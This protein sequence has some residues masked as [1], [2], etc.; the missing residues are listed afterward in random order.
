MILDE[1][2]EFCDATAAN[3]TDVSVII[4]DVMSTLVGTDNTLRDLGNGQPVYFVIQVTTAYTAAGTSVQWQLATDSTADLATSRTNHVDSGAISTVAGI[5]AGTTYIWTLP[6]EAT[7]EDFMGVWLTTVG[8]VA[9]G[10]IN[11]FLTMD[12]SRWTAYA[13]RVTSDPT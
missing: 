6:V 7:Y 4:G 5:A 13:T 11:A 9:G 3:G 12:P 1:L 8:A 2:A 10:A